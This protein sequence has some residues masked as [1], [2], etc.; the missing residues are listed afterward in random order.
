MFGMKRFMGLAA[1]LLSSHAF[2]IGS[3]ADIEIIDRATGRALPI[4]KQ[5]E[6][7][8]VAGTPGAKYAIRLRNSRFNRVLAV[9]SV[10][11]VNV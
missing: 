4:Y 2:A 5:G 9:M 1:A 10:D 3:L 11:G 7:S 6:Q 8:W